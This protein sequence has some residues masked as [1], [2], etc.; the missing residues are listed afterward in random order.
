[1]N[2]HILPPDEFEKLLPLAAAWAGEQEARILAA[3]TPLTPAQISDA[4]QMG[5]L[6]PERVRL[7]AVESIPM[8]THPLLHAAGKAAGLI[9]PYTAGLT[10][11]HGIY[12]RRDLFGDRFLVAHELVHTA[13]YE[14]CGSIIDFLR[15]Y[16]HECLTIGYPAA[17]ME[18]EAVVAAERLR[19]ER[20]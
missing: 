7:L 2:E 15:L 8:P 10:L 9:G 5:V 14:R 1:M 16:L 13:Q 20:E 6:H 19:E 17:P 11:R 12:I 3:G 18:Q 4:Q